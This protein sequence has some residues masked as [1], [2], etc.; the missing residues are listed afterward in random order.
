MPPSIARTRERPVEKDVETLPLLSAEE[1]TAGEGSESA[2]LELC[3]AL[4]SAWKPALGETPRRCFLADRERWIATAG[5]LLERHPRERLQRALDYMLVDEIVGSR[6]ITLPDFAK[7]VDQL[8]AREHARS[9][10]A[11]SRPPAASG[12]MGWPAA[13]E[14]LERSVQ[15]HGRDDRAGALAE[16]TSRSELFAVFVERV[17]WSTLCEQPMRYSD[18]HYAQLWNELAHTHAGSGR[19]VTA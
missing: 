4:I 9:N 15:R 13:R 8:L 10:R 19:E 11:G 1:E 3:E 12:G 7:L 2:D 16:L 17:R 5:E 6:A 14:L 18:G